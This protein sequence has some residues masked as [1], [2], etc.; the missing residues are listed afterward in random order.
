MH[1]HTKLISAFVLLLLANISMAQIGVCYVDDNGN[2]I[3]S[4][5]QP[6]NNVILTAVPFLRIT[7]DA[8]SGAMGDAGLALSADANAMH[9]NQS[10]MAFA[11][12]TSGFSITYTP[13]LTSLGLQDVYLTYLSG[14]HKLDERQ[15][16][17]MSLRFFSLGEINFTDEQGTAT[18]IGRPREW[19]VTGAYARQLSDKLSAAIG[20]KFIYSNLAAAD[21]QIGNVTVTPGIAGAAD[22]SL[23]Y[24]SKVGKTGELQVGMAATNIGSKITYARTPEFI[25]TNIGIG[26]AYKLK[27][28]EFNNFTFTLDINKLMVPTPPLDDSLRIADTNPPNGIADWKEVSSVSGMFNSFGDAPEGFSEE[29]TEL[30]YSA[31]VEYL[32]DEQFAVRAGYF[33]ESARKGNRKYLTVGLGL[34]Y[35]LIGLNISYLVPTSNQ[36]NPLDNT[37]RFSV[38]FEF[39]GDESGT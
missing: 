39:G 24:K 12:K 29:L 38:L 16:V 20:A 34:K 31:G 32:Y 23:T 25:P 18:G 30:S 15:A 10:R 13:W 35:N 26:A 7:P 8:R 27:V 14:Y 28:D 22:F 36:R 11:N 4:S 37:L 17:G 21:A 2:Y 1:L 3:T 9:F 19:E 5:G 6:C 33:H